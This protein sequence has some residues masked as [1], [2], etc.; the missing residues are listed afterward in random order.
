MNHLQFS[1]TNTFNGFK[2]LL[3]LLLGPSLVSKLRL[4]ES[5][6]QVAEPKQS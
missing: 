4:Q 2:F 6:F 1:T 3:I 5:C